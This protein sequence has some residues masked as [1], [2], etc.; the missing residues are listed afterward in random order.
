M[1]SPLIKLD[2]KWVPLY[3]IVYVS[4]LPHFCGE[5]DCMHEGDY[6]VRL[7]VEDSIWVNAEGR[8]AAVTELSRWCGDPGSMDDEPNY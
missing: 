4:D 8:D 5:P 6:E 2:D 3:R 1:N 7:D